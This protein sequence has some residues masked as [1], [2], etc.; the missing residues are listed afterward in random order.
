M[1]GKMAGTVMELLMAA[2]SSI[3]QEP[4]TQMELKTQEESQAKLMLGGMCPMV[5]AV[6]CFNA[7]PDKCEDALAEFDKMTPKSEEDTTRALAEDAS[8]QDDLKAQCE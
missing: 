3:G 5:T 4:P 6:T 8:T 1:G 7:N 2:F